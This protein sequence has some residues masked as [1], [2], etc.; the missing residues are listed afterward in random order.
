MPDLPDDLRVALA[1]CL[2]AIPGDRLRTSVT[3]LI[4]A[5]RSGAVPVTPILAGATDVAAYAAYRM[6]ATFS[7]VQAALS[8]LR[9]VAPGFMPVSHLDL[10]GGTGAAAWAAVSSFD[11]LRAI[12]VVD[13]V[14]AALRFGELLAGDSGSAALRSAR[15]LPGKLEDEAPLGADLVTV[16]YVMGELSGSRQRELVDRAAASAGA[17]VIV[18]PGTPAGYERILRARDR[19][20]E[21]GSVIVAPCPHQM[22]CPLVAGDWCHFGVRVNRSALH[23]RLKDGDLSYEDEKFSYVVALPTAAPARYGRVLR[24]PVQRKG[25][26]ALRLCRSDGTGSEQIV[27]RSHG[28]AYRSARDSAWGDPWRH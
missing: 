25:L 4:E 8:A 19:L 2:V 21:L 10:G 18:E 17:V 13:Q 1:A 24:R 11:G 15:W 16:S 26:V 3:R 14:G 22:V 9:D 6:P 20:I 28:D 7:A 12:T 27:A 5:Y 23:R